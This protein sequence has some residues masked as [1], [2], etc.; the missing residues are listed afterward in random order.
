[1][2][3]FAAL[4][5]DNPEIGPTPHYVFYGSPDIRD[6]MLI[7]AHHEKNVVSADIAFPDLTDD[8]LECAALLVTLDFPIYDA[9]LDAY[10][11]EKIIRLRDRVAL[12]VDRAIAGATPDMVDM[13]TWVASFSVAETTFSVEIDGRGMTTT[14][15]IDQG[16]LDHKALD[17]LVKKSI[18]SIK[19]AVL[20]V[21]L[22]AIPRPPFLEA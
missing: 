19:R 7:A 16:K 14:L 20:P 15:G 6:R 4:K 13:M 5:F 17:Y 1:M 11:S 12:D 2:S 18:I 8:E 3:V 10:C 9:V 22:R 21:V